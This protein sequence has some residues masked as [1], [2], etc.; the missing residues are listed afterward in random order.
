MSHYHPLFS[1]DQARAIDRDAQAALG[2][3]EYDLMQRAGAAAW[4]ELLNHWSNAQ[5]I[6]I[7][8]GPGNNGG[9]GLVLA[10]IARASGRTVVVLTLPDGASCGDTARQALAGWEGDGGDVSTFDG[11]LPV[12]D[13]WVDALFGIGFS[14]APVGAARDL[15]EAINASDAD[16]FALDV[17]SGVDADSGHVPGVAIRASRTLCFIGD[18]RGLHTGAA[19]D[20]VGKRQVDALAVPNEILSAHA[21]VARLVRNSVLAD[22]LPRR[23]LDSNKGSFGHVLC[24]GGDHG[25]AGAIALTSEAAL[26][27]GSGL[28]SVATR[29][30]HVAMLLARRPELMVSG[31][32]DSRGFDAACV[33]ASVLAVGPGMG[34]GEWGQAL[35]AAALKSGKPLVLDADALN[36]IARSPRALPDAVLT[37]HPGEA[38]RL[39]GVATAEIQADRFGAAERLA[40]RYGCCVVLKG[41][42]TVIAGPDVV[43]VVIAAGNPGMATGGMGD[44]LTGV[45]AAMRAQGLPAFDAAVCGALL[46]GQAGDAAARKSGERG[47]LA[48]D[49]FMELH[50][51]ANPRD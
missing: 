16:V 15:I 22:W 14:R 51:Q 19:L 36:L 7:A 25:T 9:D 12:V 33:R 29:A 44:V 47:L 13:L 2:L 32:E 40:T 43:P 18:K 34:T 20:Q 3:S 28:V 30:D 26:R 48:S 45:I 38:G 46:H 10:Q 24:V 49:L 37:P 5:R 35:L 17:P 31:I 8:C 39:L 50:W 42:G 23:R 1:T 4:R 21:P 27:S 41:A 11:T 6:G